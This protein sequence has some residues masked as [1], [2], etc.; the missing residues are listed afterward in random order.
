MRFTS[1]VAVAVAPSILV[2]VYPSAAQNSSPARET[3]STTVIAVPTAD[4]LTIRRNLV[5]VRVR[6]RG[7]T[8]PN[9]GGEQ[10]RQRVEG[11][12]LNKIV[13]FDVHGQEVDTIL[14]ADVFTEGGGNL[15]QE[16]SALAVEP[17]RPAPV[18]PAAPAP[19]PQVTK[20]PTSPTQAAAPAAGGASGSRGDL[21]FPLPDRGTTEFQ[22]EADVT[23]DPFDSVDTTLQILPYLNRNFQAGGRLNYRRIEG[24][25][26]DFDFTLW[27][28][29]LGARYNFVGRSRTVP[30]LSAYFGYANVDI[31]IADDDSFLYGGQI[32]VKQF[33]NRN[34]SLDF[35]FIYQDYSENDIEE[36]FGFRIGLSTY[37]R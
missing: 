34:T 19:A 31:D 27:S 26:D 6:I 5:E 14:V 22:I 33:L 25:D 3:F 37:L 15:A 23:F 36:D 16:V 29:A 30:F 20:A 13:R 24:G 1:F 32:G 18:A 9:A 12:V 7:L 10:L 2:S 4:T 11:L 28:L 35:T 21:P 17:V 8:V